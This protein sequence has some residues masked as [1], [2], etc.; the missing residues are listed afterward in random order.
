MAKDKYIE[1]QLETSMLSSVLLL[2][3]MM[4]IVIMLYIIKENKTAEPLIILVSVISK[5]K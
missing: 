2:N 4:Q 3:F 5:M 1:F